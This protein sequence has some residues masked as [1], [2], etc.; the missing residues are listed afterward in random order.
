MTDAI[1]MTTLLVAAL[2]LRGNFELAHHFFLEEG[3]LSLDIL[4]ATGLSKDF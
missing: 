2:R 4:P 3:C 1:V